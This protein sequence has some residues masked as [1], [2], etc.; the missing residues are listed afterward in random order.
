PR[1]SHPYSVGNRPTRRHRVGLSY[2]CVV[3][4]SPNLVPEVGGEKA[5]F[6]ARTREAMTELGIIICE[7]RQATNCV[8]VSPHSPFLPEAFGVW[9]GKKLKGSMGRF[10]APEITL[11]VKVS[12]ELA[13][14]IVDVAG[15]MEL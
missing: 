9:E 11:E 6:C 8:I 13:E 1:W 15:R 10:Q 7:E 4:H 3:P 12:T 2:G 5:Q 14:A